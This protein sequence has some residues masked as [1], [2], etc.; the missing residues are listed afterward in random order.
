[1]RSSND[2]NPPSQTVQCFLCR[3]PVRLIDGDTIPVHWNGRRKCRA[4]NVI[5]DKPSR[6]LL[7]SKAVNEIPMNSETTRE[8]GQ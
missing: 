6:N 3:K 8:D 2:P 7:I 4:S 1:M 5:V